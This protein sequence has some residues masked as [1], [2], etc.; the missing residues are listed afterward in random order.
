MGFWNDVK[1]GVGLGLGGG[2][3]W[4]LGTKLANLVWRVLAIAVTGGGVVLA[5][6][7]GWHP[8]GD[9][10]PAAQVQQQHQAAPARPQ[11]RLQQQP[12]QWPGVAK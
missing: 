11:Q 2:F 6:L 7:L 5:N 3:G 1:K 8:G 10:K 9:H 12:Q 4:T